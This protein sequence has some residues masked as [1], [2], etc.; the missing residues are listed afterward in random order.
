MDDRAWLLTSVPAGRDRSG[1]E[2]W[3]AVVLAAWEQADLASFAERLPDLAGE[4][5]FAATD[6][7]SFLAGLFD[8]ASPEEVLLLLDRIGPG[9]LAA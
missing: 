5:G 2:L 8:R 9:V 4:H 1:A 6:V 7:E 3:F